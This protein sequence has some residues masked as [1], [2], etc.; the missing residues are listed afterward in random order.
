[1]EASTLEEIVRLIF[2]DPKTCKWRKNFVECDLEKVVG[3]RVLRPKRLMVFLTCALGACLSMAFLAGCSK[4]SSG[5]SK[6]EDQRKKTAIPVTVGAAVQKTVP[7][8]LSAVGNV[9]AY[10]TVEVR[11]R[12]GGELVAVHFKEGQ[13][14]KKGDLL[15]TIDP[16]PYESQLKQAEAN[17]A[18][19]R[20]Q[21]HNA[22]KQVERYA[23]VV[24]KGYVAEEHYD[25]VKANSGALEGSVRADEAAVENAKLELKFC[26]IRS[27]IDGAIGE[28]KVNQGNLIKPN[29]N[30]KPMVIIRQVSPVYVAFAV[31][32]RNLPEVKKYMALH[33][34]EVEATPQGEGGRPARGELAFMENTV[35]TT[36][37][38]IQLKAVFPNADK[39]L[40]PGQFVSVRLK[41]T[42]L[43]DVVVIPAQAVQAGQDGHY[44]YVVKPDRTVEYR[45]ITAGPSMEGEMV[46]E[47]GVAVGDT[48]V[49][50][51]QLRL[52][53]G[54]LVKI[55]EGSEKST[56]EASS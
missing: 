1:M 30:D 43:P 56:A 28:L 34:L 5:K 3:R 41:L 23:S 54:S 29:D 40:W 37:G 27:P 32:E 9:Q 25:Q 48:V 13:D 18:R 53:P 2:L 7:M 22:L 10:S 35:D 42:S 50:D 36:T 44:V 45:V 12:V 38:T 11:A 6:V 20:A 51:G 55:V 47:K 21:L 52:A 24:Q 19:N 26:T 39:A 17:L 46:I 4:D 14:V 8:M 16:R 31:P 49:T 33:K 15:F